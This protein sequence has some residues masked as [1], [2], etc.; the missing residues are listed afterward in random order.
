VNDDRSARFLDDRFALSDAEFDAW[1]DALRTDAEARRALQEQLA[2]DDVLSRALDPDR[3]NF[4]AQVLYRVRDAMAGTRVIRERRAR[5]LT[6][7]RGAA[8]R[9]RA[10]R[11]RRVAGWIALGAAAAAGLRSND[12]PPSRR[13]SSLPPTRRW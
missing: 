6:T 12:A 1:L 3:A 13:A 9:D 2:M 11:V 8:G 4:R 5:I 7:I 10:R